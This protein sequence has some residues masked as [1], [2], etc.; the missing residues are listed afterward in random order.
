[1]NNRR[2]GMFDRVADNAGAEKCSG[3]HSATNPF[4]RN[5]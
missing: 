3:I 1:V 4:A 5:S 2:A